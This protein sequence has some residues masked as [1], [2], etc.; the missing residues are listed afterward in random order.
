[1]SNNEDKTKVKRVFMLTEAGIQATS[2]RCDLAERYL[3]MPTHTQSN[4]LMMLQADVIK[5]PARIEAIQQMAVA[6]G[7]AKETTIIE[8]TAQAEPVAPF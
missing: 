7:W 2:K 8:P 6:L 5:D 3:K 4:L 1:M